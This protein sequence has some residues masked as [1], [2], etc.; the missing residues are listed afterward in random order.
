[1]AGLSRRAGRSQHRHPQRL[2]ARVPEGGRQSPH[3]RTARRAKSL[4]T[5]PRHHRGRHLALHA[6][7]VGLLRLLQPLSSR[8][9]AAAPTLEALR[10]PG[11]PCPRRGTRPGVC[12]PHLHPR[13]QAEDRRPDRP[14]RAGHAVRD[15]EPRLDEPRDQEGSA[16][17]T[18]HRP[19]QDRLPRHLARLLVAHHQTRRLLRQH[20]PRRQ[21]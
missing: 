4:L 1:M 11:R 21:L 20:R 16:P 19:Q 9:P 7:R 3:H 17:Q 13:D 8:N 18:P 12:P 14:D 2:P 15:R 6:V 5:L 10:S